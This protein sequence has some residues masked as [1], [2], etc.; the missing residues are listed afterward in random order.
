MSLL[1][2]CLKPVFIGVLGLKRS[3]LGSFFL[4]SVTEK[5]YQKISRLIC[6]GE[7]EFPIQNQCVILSNILMSVLLIANHLEFV[8]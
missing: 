1:D 3:A 5:S 6:L 8:S 4:H 2:Q 7:L